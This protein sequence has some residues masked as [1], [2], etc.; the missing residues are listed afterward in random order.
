MITTPLER[1]PGAVPHARAGSSPP[2]PRCPSGTPMEADV[3]RTRTPDPVAA[4]LS[5]DAR[6]PLATWRCPEC[7]C[8]QPRFE[9]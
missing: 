8:L 9:G 3:M 5:A 4:D 2:C 1:L 6:P 7:G